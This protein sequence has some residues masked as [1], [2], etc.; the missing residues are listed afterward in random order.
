MRRLGARDGGGP[1]E[2]KSPLRRDDWETHA[3][4][5]QRSMGQDYS[6]KGGVLPFSTFMNL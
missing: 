6:Q 5:F 2:N 3:K 1:M 4:Q